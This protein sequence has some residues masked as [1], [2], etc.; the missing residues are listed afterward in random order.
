MKNQICRVIFLL[1]V[2][3]LTACGNEIPPLVE[4]TKSA[5][6]TSTATQ[7]VFDAAYYDGII[8]LT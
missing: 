8:V 4:E 7:I 6:Q 3:T 2:L 1:L 5:S